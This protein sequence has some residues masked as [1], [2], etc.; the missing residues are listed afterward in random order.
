M[1]IN[2]ILLMKYCVGCVCSIAVPGGAGALPG[3]PHVPGWLVALVRVAA[4]RHGQVESAAQHRGRVTVVPG[5]QRGQRPP[6][7]LVY[8]YINTLL[9]YLP[10]SPGPRAA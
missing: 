8:N 5:G 3:L 2:R 7:P 10:V 6:A 1:F 4:V 9:C